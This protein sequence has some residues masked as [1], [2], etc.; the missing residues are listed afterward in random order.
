R[1]GAGPQGGAGRRGQAR[2]AFLGAVQHHRGQLTLPSG[3]PP[4]WPTRPPAPRRR[5]RLVFLGFNAEDAEESRR[6]AE[7]HRRVTAEAQRTQGTAADAGLRF[8]DVVPPPHPDSP[9]WGGGATPPHENG[10][11][12]S[13]VL[14]VLCA[15][16]V[17][18]VL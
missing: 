18:A 17:S 11:A 9:G 3:H 7:G 12:R 4:G 5:P 14:C 10:P 8:T 15:S 13:A 6:A 2:G 1:R 16:A